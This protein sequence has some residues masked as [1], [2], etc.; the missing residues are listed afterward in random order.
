M[1]P[2]SPMISFAVRLSQADSIGIPVFISGNAMY[3]AEMDADFNIQTFLHFENEDGY[4]L[5]FDVPE[6]YCQREFRVGDPAPIIFWISGKSHIVE[7]DAEKAVLQSQFGLSARTHPVLQD[8]GEM[9]H[10][11]RTGKFKAQQEEWLAQDITAAFDDVFLD[12]PSRTRY[13][14]ARYRVALEEARRLTT[15]PHPIDARLRRVSHE[16]LRRFA[17]K[18]ELPMITSMLGEAAQGIFSGRQIREIMFAY[19]S[20]RL[21]QARG[22][23][24]LQISSDPAILSLF[25]N[26]LY[27]YFLEQG[28][29]HVP[30]Q[31]SKPDFIGLMKEK[32]VD[33]WE[34]GNWKTALLVSKLVFGDRDAPNEIDGTAL[35]YIRQLQD[36]YKKSLNSVEKH[37]N[38]RGFSASGLELSRNA[39][40]VI[41]LYER[42]GELSCIIHG[43]DRVRG[44]ILQGRY[45]AFKDDVTLCR[46][47]V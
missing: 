37:F 6:N 39:Q 13:W 45:Q 41:D 4:D 35:I 24:I 36:A 27:S 33:G 11:A 14:I 23:D 7:G 46:N 12:S 30:F 34:R 8:L 32:L 26:G 18:S 31:Y 15:P 42:I 5:T 10:D 9:L 38:S 25:S 44:E 21:S 2:I 3:I 40:A 43:D 29:P 19:L 20:H 16:W 22:W 47:Y 17:T 28:W 1:T